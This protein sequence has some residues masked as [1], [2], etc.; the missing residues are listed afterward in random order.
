MME[1]MSD[2]VCRGLHAPGLFLC[3]RE[4]AFAST[5]FK[6]S[7]VFRESAVSEARFPRRTLLGSSV[8]RGR[9]PLTPAIIRMGR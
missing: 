2:R 4:V 3:P 5:D 7:W 1:S 8:N 6:V 9:R